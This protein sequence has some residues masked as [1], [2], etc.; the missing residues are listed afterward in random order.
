MRL[1][2]FLTKNKFYSSREKAQQFIKEGFVKINGNVCTKSSFCVNENDLIEIVKSEK[3]VSR[4]AY[5]LLGAIEKFNIVFKDKVVLDVGA[6]TGGF[7][8]VALEQGAKKV[9]AVDVGKNQL[10]HELIN[11]IRV[12]NLPETDVRNLKNSDVFDSEIIVGDLSFISLTKILPFLNQL[13]SQKKEM[14]FLFKPQFECGIEIAKKYRGIINNKE[15]HYKILENFIEF[16]K[17]NNINISDL[18]FSPIRGGDGNIEYLIYFNSSVN[19][20]INIKKVIDCAFEFL[21]SN[22]KK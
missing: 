21:N 16:A 15:I 10:A 19:K 11:D 18:T 20:K 7:T 5:K 3:Y 8:Q 12:V 1:D 13:F 4:G 9:Y 17:L 6:S 22:N 2:V 14:M